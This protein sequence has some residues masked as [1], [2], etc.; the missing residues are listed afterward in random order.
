MRKLTLE[1]TGMKCEGC[2]GAVDAALG[3]VEGVRRVDVSLE[4]GRADVVGDDAL[5]ADDLVAAV[6]AAGYDAAP[7]G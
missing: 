3:R 2:A 6:E 4:D 5:A 7:A 1:V